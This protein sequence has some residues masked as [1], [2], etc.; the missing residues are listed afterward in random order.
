MDLA[1]KDKPVIVA[2]ASKGLGRAIAERLGREGARVA[3]FART[4]RALSDAAAA[5]VAAGG[6]AISVAGD[7]T[8]PADVARVVEATVDRF[9]GLYG[10]VTNSGGPPS[11]PFV[12]L[13]AGDWEDA[14]RL[15]V[16]GAG[17]LLRNALPYLQASRGSVV[18]I[19]SFTIKQ[20]LNG[21]ILSN[22]LRLAV[23]GM[24]KTL[25]NEWGPHGIRLNTV[26]PGPF[27]TE[28]LLT[29]TQAYADRMGVTYAEAE[30]RL[31][32]DQ[33]P[34]GRLGE[35]AEFADAV[36]FLLSP[37][38]SFITGVALQVD[39]GIVKGIL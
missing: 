4:A 15:L 39:G 38:A 9:G 33:I 10:V 16:H 8:N 28:R 18:A 17:A 22:S 36:T 32:T 30:K 27:A 6:E 29:L 24:I 34:L 12:E 1:L 23:T 25:A 21:L 7:V 14:S 37:R 11:R 3:L 2:G 13:S 19:T 35:P 31:W 5:V 26:C 20:P